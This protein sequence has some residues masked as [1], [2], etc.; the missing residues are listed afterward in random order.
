MYMYI[1]IYIYLGV[2][3]GHLQATPSPPIKSFP[4]GPA[5]LMLVVL[6]SVS[7]IVIVFSY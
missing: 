1:Y 2:W 6:V 5:I 7:F 3:S 4:T